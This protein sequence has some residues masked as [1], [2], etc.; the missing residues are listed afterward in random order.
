MI[1][2]LYKKCLPILLS[3]SLVFGWFAGFGGVNSAQA[4]S[5]SEPEILLQRNAEWNYF[6]QGQDLLTEWRTY[7]DLSSWKMGQAP[8]GY[9]DNGNGVSTSYFGPLK[10][11]VSYGLD[12][13]L[14]PRTTYFRTNLNVNKDQ[15]NSYGQILGT[16]GIDDG[17]VIYVNGEEIGRF[18]MPEG[19]VLYSTKAAS[20]QDLPVMY[21]NV[22]L[23]E[24]L[25]AKLQDGT[26]VIA[27]EVRQQL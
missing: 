25:K 21:E 20:S 11:E 14:K 9:K 4:A 16:F 8:F 6:D 15:I 23:T 17:A 7:D 3:L 26:N 10:T 27:V 5:S 24:P 22:D 18:G 2:H 1:S 13:E 19:E 12:K